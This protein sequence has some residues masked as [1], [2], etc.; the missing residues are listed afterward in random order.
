M[1]RYKD[2]RKKIGW[3]KALKKELKTIIDSGTLINKE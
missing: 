3:I 1:L 2:P